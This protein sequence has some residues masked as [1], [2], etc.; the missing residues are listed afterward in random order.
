[1]FFAIT[2]TASDRGKRSATEKA[3]LDELAQVI[4]LE[5][6]EWAAMN[7]GSKHSL[8]VR[9]REDGVIPDAGDDPIDLERDNFVEGIV[10][11]GSRLLRS[12]AP[13]LNR[14]K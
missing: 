10:A 12:V 5:S 9:L 6:S 1:M 11:G 3:T 14:P 2:A 13:H 4:A 8:I 7:L